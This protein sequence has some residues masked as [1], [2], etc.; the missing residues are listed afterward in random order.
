MDAVNKLIAAGHG[1]FPNGHSSYQ[2]GNRWVK[3]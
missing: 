3:D 1:E 2:A